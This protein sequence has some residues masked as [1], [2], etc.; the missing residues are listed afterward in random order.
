MLSPFYRR[1]NSL[2]EVKTTWQDHTT[3]Y[4]LSQDLA[5][6]LSPCKA[7][8]FSLHITKE[9]SDFLAS[10]LSFL[11]RTPPLPCCS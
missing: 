1:E 9:N 10:S 3:D 11:G 4:L 8:G 2:I 5:P 6:I 7:Y